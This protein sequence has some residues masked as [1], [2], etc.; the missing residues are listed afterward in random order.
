[1]HSL[2]AQDT[3]VYVMVS[4]SAVDT[5]MGEV[6]LK[7]IGNIVK[8]LP[9]FEGYSGD[10]LVNAS[11]AC[12]DILENDEGLET[13]LGMAAQLPANLQETAYALAAEIAA[14]D[15]KV[16]AEEVRFLQLLRGRLS[17]DKLTCAA[18]ERAAQARHQT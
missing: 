16:A 7:R 11:K 1:M 4:I 15:L 13:V 6:E 14:S 3:L 9:V 10:Q 8:T 5:N 12:A 17:V 18:L 2:S